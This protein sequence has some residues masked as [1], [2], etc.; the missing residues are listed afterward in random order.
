M[1][2]PSITNSGVLA[3]LRSFILSVLPAPIEVVR[4]QDNFVT[5]PSTVDFVVVTSM[6]R[7][8]LATNLISYTD[9]V[10]GNVHLR[11]V[12]EKTE[13]TIQLDIHGPASEENTQVLSSLLRDTYAFDLLSPFGVFPLYTDDPR[14]MPFTN[15]S[16]QYEDRWT[17]DVT[18]QLNPVV[19]VPQSFADSA[20]IGFYEVD[21]SFSG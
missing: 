13:I 8:R 1:T 15:E 14:Q 7:V 19:P 17:L 20:K 10:P 18:L 16:G 5:E 21:S 11:N 3:A 12:L 6:G 9:D 4:G 2:V